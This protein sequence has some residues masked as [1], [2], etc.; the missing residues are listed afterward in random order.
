MDRETM[1][2]EAALTKAVS[3]AMTIQSAGSRNLRGFSLNGD[4]SKHERLL[5]YT[6]QW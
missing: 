1:G 2:S 6:G 3:A 4:I 5:L